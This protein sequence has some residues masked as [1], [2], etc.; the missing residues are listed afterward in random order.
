MT[1]VDFIPMVGDSLEVTD[2]QA[3]ILLTFQDANSAD[4]FAVWMGYWSK[5]Q[6]VKEYAPPIQMRR[7]AAASNVSLNVLR[8]SQEDASD[9]FKRRVVLTQ[10]GGHCYFKKY[11]D[12]DNMCAV[13]EGDVTWYDPDVDAGML[14]FASGPFE[15]FQKLFTQEGDTASRLKPSE[16]AKPGEA[17]LEYAFYAVGSQPAIDFLVQD[18]SSNRKSLVIPIVA[19]GQQQQLEDKCMEDTSKYAEYSKIEIMA[20]YRQPWDSSLTAT[21]PVPASTPAPE[22]SSDPATSAANSSDPATTPAPAN[23]SDQSLATTPPASTA[24]PVAST[25]PTNANDSINLLLI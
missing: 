15:E 23:I 16:C 12:G 13:I 7:I 17:Q 8:A 21:T 10:E 20:L 9:S 6:H 24:G 5:D 11:S 22:N 4:P 19:Q 14:M 2:G 18:V 1:N 3:G 25:D